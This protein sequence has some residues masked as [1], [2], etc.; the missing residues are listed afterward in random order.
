LTRQSCLNIVGAVM[1][2]V[3]FAFGASCTFGQV[4]SASMRQSVLIDRNWTFH[5]GDLAGAEKP[6]YTD[7]DWERVNLPHSFS[8]PYFRSPNFYMG[9]GW[10]RKN[11]YINAN[12]GKR[13][14]LEFDG[15]FRVAEIYVNGKLVGMHSG[16][17]TGFSFDITDKVVSGNNL[18][19][20]RVNNLWNARL[21]PRAGEHVFSGGIYR[22]V[23]LVET[24]DLHV[25][26]YG[27]FVTTP[28]LSEDGAPVYISTEIRNETLQKFTFLL[29]TAVLDPQGRK[30]ETVETQQELTGKTTQSFEQQTPFVEHPQLWSPEHPALYTA[31]STILRDGK[32]VD[33]YTTSF[34]FRFISWT[35]DKGFFL[36]GQHR[37]FHGANV[38]Q[39]HAGWG[40]AVS[41]DGIARD[42]N[43]IKQAGFDFI[44]GSHYPHSPV[45][46]DECDRQGILFWSENSFWGIGGAHG[47]ATWTSSAYPT[48]LADQKPFE[49]GVKTNLA[50]MIR[51]NRNHPSI[52]AW[53]MGN[54]VFF[55]DGNVML[56]LRDLL[57]ALVQETHEL[58]PTRPAAIGGSQRGEIDHLGDVAGYNGDGARLYIDPG[59]PSAV[60][61][62]GSTVADRPG[63]YEPGFGELGD[64]PQFSWR[65][66]QAIWCG[67]DHG[68]IIPALSRMGIIDYFRIPKRSWYWYRNAYKGITPPK[69]PSPGIASALRL[70]ADARKITHADGRG[71]RQIMITV[72]DAQGNEISNTPTV[73]LEIL[74]GPGE[75]PTGRS[76][77]F[78]SKSDI[79][80]LDGKAAIEIRAYESGVIHLR[81]SS[82][83]LK[84]ADMV[85]YAKGGPKFVFGKAQIVPERPY[86]KT[87][88]GE[89]VLGPKIEVALNHPT[90]ASSELQ[91][92]E[93]RFA[94]DGDL[95]TYWQPLSNIDNVSWWQLDFEN[96]IQVESLRATFKDGKDHRY[97]IELSRDGH[98]W[99]TVASHMPNATT[100]TIQF[101]LSK[102]SNCRGIALRVRFIGESPKN[103]QLTDI[104]VTGRPVF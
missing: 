49:E 81:A 25:T 24:S 79:A 28:K 43:L 41:N 52:I 44:R 48:K 66:G 67:F 5:L 87:S 46:A 12:D 59:I 38:H 95:S 55:S 16:G 61:E 20:I 101:D 99:K 32:P 103:L 4:K 14:F 74:S 37:Y 98:E 83:G 11:L 42:I 104:H 73:K 96:E 29:Q 102:A 18:I 35:A 72:L 47:E 92:H 39:D 2:A 70:T 21:N 17:Y 36:N 8:M 57:K 50:E 64:Q 91:G 100:Q 86:L 7:Q 23:R 82:P 53:S 60:T 89:H 27:T 80:I 75:L 31:V 30:I 88:T 13:H 34:G 63:K 69:W 6:S 97:D 77:V 3:I 56:K 76:I 78:D 9:Y 1:A 54:E 62:Y 65:S 85:I 90:H 15:V 22:N 40:D 33:R 68:S 45:F 19:A 10:Y 93:G 51:I 71:S 58:D 94:N 26:W 84:S